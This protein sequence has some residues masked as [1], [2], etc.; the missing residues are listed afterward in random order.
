MA[1]GNSEAPGSIYDKSYKAFL[2]PRLSDI[3]KRQGKIS[4]RKTEAVSF[5]VQKL[6]ER[7]PDFLLKCY[8]Q[9]DEAF[10]LHVEYQSSIDYEMAHRMHVYAALIHGKYKLPVR[11]FVLYVGSQRYNL[12]K[13]KVVGPDYYHSHDVWD[14]GR[15]DYEELLNSEYPEEVLLAIH[16]NFKGKTAEEV[17]RKIIQRLKSLA[18]NRQVLKRYVTH[19]AIIS[20]LQRLENVVIKISREMEL[21]DEKQF[22]SY[23]KGVKEGRRKGKREGK[24]EGLREAAMKQ[25][26]RGLISDEIIAED[27]DLSLEEIAQIRQELKARGEL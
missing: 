6:L 4:I 22:P 27:F 5:E 21:L 20:N 24:R 12:E 23:Q 26:K 19:L 9:Q 7:R 15:Q 1:K 2:E 13:T 10:I 3:L 16:S 18:V 25:I 17:V 14:I 11:Q 8:D